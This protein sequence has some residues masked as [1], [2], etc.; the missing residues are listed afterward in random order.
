MVAGRPRPLPAAIGDELVAL[1]RQAIANIVAHADARTARVGLVYGAAEVVLLVQ[2]DGV[3]FDVRR[4]APTGR[5][6]GRRA[7]VRASP[8]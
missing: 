5:P 2:D 7:A 4:I 8:S 1:G 6:Q 3:G